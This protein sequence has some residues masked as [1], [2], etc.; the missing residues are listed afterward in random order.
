MGLQ[1]GWQFESVRLVPLDS[2]E[3]YSELTP[4]TL[5]RPVSQ[6]I[7]AEATRA[8]TVNRPESCRLYTDVGCIWDIKRSK[9][10]KRNQGVVSGRPE[11]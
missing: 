4:A 1:P 3:H 5:P 10:S 7:T 9:A 2:I 6:P 11:L 8:S